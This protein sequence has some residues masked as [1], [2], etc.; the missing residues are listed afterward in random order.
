MLP[1]TKKA[2]L[3]HPL[4]S[5]FEAQQHEGLILL[6][7]GSKCTGK[8]TLLDTISETA[9]KSGALVL[10]ATGFPKEHERSFDV[11]RHIL[12]QLEQA[13]AQPIETVRTSSPDARS[14]CP[15]TVTPEQGYRRLL[16]V[17][18][19]RPVL[20]AVDDV[21]Y[22]DLPSQDFLHFLAR[23]LKGTR[24]R[25][26]LVERTGQA[27]SHC[28]DLR[29]D[30]LRLPYTR[31]VPLRL[32]SRERITAWISEQLAALGIPEVKTATRQI[33]AEVHALS[34]GN[35]MLV[36]LLVR[37][38]LAASERNP[39][40]LTID[41][42]FYESVRIVLDDPDITGIRR[43][44][45]AAAV[46]G[47]FCS[48]HRLSLLLGGDTVLANRFLRT[49]EDLG[50]MDGNHLRQPIVQALID[51]Q[52]FTDRADVHL[53]AAR[54]L[55]EDGVPPLS[56]TRHLTAAGKLDEQSDLPLVTEL[57]SRL[58][59]DDDVEAA[60]AL[61]RLV[62]S[63]ITADA[64]SAVE[65]L[66]LRS[67]WLTD[68]PLA[69]SL[70]P[71]LVGAALRGALDTADVAFLVR[72]GTLHGFSDE[73]RELIS[74]LR[75]RTPQPDH[76]IEVI[77]AEALYE[78]WH[79]QPLCR[80]RS[81]FVDLDTSLDQIS[82]LNIGNHPW[83]PTALFKIPEL[84]RRGDRAGAIFAAEQILEGVRV[85]TSGVEPFLAACELLDRLGSLPTARRWCVK[86][87]EAL[88]D[89]PSPIWK[90]L[91]STVQAKISFNLGDLVGAYRFI[92]EALALKAWQEWG[93]GI[94]SLAALLV[95]TLTEMGRY[96]EAAEVL[97]R[98]V[99]PDVFGGRA[100]LLY[101]R[102]R[103]HYHLAV[104]RLH[105]AVAD[106]EHCRDTSDF[107]NIEPALAMPW[108]CDMARAYLGME[109]IQG[110]RDLLQEQLKLL[111][112][113][114]TP[115]RGVALRLL[116]MTNEADERISLL[117]LSADQLERCGS[118]LQ[119]AYTLAALASAYRKTPGLNLAR[120]TIG[121]AQRMAQQCSAGRLH[122]LIT[123]DITTDAA[124]D[125][126][127]LENHDELA[128]LSSAEQRVAVLAIQ[129][130]TNREI[131]TRLFITTSTVEQHLTR[132]Y[133]K[134]EVR[135]RKDL[136]DRFSPL[137][138]Q[139]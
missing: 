25:L 73:A 58:L 26:A 17:A 93:A 30:V 34:G 78:I 103:G 64:R 9:A 49:L 60:I 33:A 110:A 54:V 127:A 37:K 134:L 87:S 104:G 41:A 43:G 39:N 65:V 90:A 128:K 94:G 22:V 35:I 56:V 123:M 100:G 86:L 32:L 99:P 129:G 119:L 46:L 11:L 53:E 8:T 63:C 95:E 124:E 137:S 96:E 85:K 133:R 70:V 13:A 27:V 92:Q 107:L 67:Q 117:K 15:A 3:P 71:Q 130:H 19:K 12:G 51:D 79:T 135:H 1:F 59:E 132:I 57:V 112:E 5:E 74:M 88:E 105:A 31:V 97:D 6:I 52:N 50:M 91:L 101:T 115:V 102:A 61:L 68:L 82:Y 55:F 116:A 118:R 80:E 109:N 131:S 4:I 114:D 36:G 10:W 2:I 120:T 122:E 139:L 18:A 136:E 28:D 138:L 47:R 89:F 45:W 62:Q 24:I 125:G 42:D 66:L 111:P 7:R 108:R 83:L 29:T 106:F 48:P 38:Y 98:P 121:K 69:A 20:I 76:L 75:Q 16:K 84:M 23:R 14:L 113:E 81:G 126:N 72:A 77:L 44:A 40:E 21:N